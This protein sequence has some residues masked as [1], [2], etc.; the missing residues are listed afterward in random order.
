MFAAKTADERFFGVPVY[1]DLHLK[2][3]ADWRDDDRILDQ[4]GVVPTEQGQ[5]SAR[6]LP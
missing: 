3:R 6:R 2:V 4:A 5:E 1:L